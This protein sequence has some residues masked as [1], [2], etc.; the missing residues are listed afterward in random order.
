[1]V[2]YEEA[3]ITN[4][5]VFPNDHKK[6]RVH[7]CRTVREHNWISTIK[8]AVH[9]TYSVEDRVRTK[10]QQLIVREQSHTFFY[11]Y[12]HNPSI[13]FLDIFQ[14]VFKVTK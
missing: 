4:A 1:M 7:I 13:N 14:I 10:L 3:Y 6:C 12:D 9:T 8:T 5:Q 11:F 2:L